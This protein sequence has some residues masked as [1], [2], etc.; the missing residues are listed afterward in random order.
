MWVRVRVRV[1]VRM[2]DM[3]R[4]RFMVRVRGW[5][6]GLGLGVRA[7]ELQNT[8]KIPTKCQYNTDIIPIRITVRKREITIQ[9]GIMEDQRG[10]MFHIPKMG[11][12][13]LRE[14]IFQKEDV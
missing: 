7:G 1:R 2:R 13:L 12:L 14:T 11:R 10:I 6:S 3:F 5:G 4:V 9:R 8:H